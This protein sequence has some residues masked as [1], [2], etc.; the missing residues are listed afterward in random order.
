MSKPPGISRRGHRSTGTSST[1]TRVG[2]QRRP[3][4]RIRAHD[5]HW[6]PGAGQPSGPAVPSSSTLI[7]RT[8][9]GSLRDARCERGAN[10]DAAYGPVGT[11][12]PGPYG[13]VTSVGAVV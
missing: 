2:S 3:A 8:L 10:A 9:E 13:D 1:T 5:A 7:D 6:Q 11:G 12:P 4:A